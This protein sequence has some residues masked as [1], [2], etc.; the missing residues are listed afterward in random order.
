MGGEPGS[1]RGVQVCL[2]G[3]LVVGVLVPV[4][5]AHYC[6]STSGLSTHW[7]GG[8]LHNQVVVGNVILKQA[9]RLDAF[10]GYPFRT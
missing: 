8:C 5:S 9:S 7:S 3:V 1:G 4:S 10:S 2:C 6:V